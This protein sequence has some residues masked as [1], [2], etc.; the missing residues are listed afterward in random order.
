[1][2]LLGNPRRSRVAATYDSAADHFDLAPLSFWDRHGRRAVHHA[3]LRPGESVLDVGC[4]TG[5]SALPAASTV[6]PTGSVIG[7]DIA[8]AMLTRAGM[9]AKAQRLSNMRFERT[10]MTSL[11]FPSETFDAVISVFSVFFVEDV[12]AQITELWRVL[13][14]GGR[15]VLTFWGKDAF[16]PGA[17]IFTEELG[18]LRPDIPEPLRAWERLTSRNA[19]EDLIASATNVVPEVHPAPDQQSLATPRDWWTIVMGSGYRWEIDQLTS[20]ERQ[21]LEQR[22]SARIRA[23]VI[24]AISVPAFHAVAGKP[25]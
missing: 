18:T 11:S 7:I 13:R 3:S 9:K 5:A 20:D 24:K 19:I 1:M 10:D 23:E 6:G 15:L 16:Q 2:T 21:R 12:E 17:A 14:P 4:G 22:C 8:E 25:I